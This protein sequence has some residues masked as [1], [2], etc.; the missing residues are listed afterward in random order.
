MSVSHVLETDSRRRSNGTTCRFP[1]SLRVFLRIALSYL[2]MQ[3]LLSVKTQLLVDA[4]L[5]AFLSASHPVSTNSHQPTPAMASPPPKLLRPIVDPSVCL[6]WYHGRCYY[7][8]CKYRHSL[9][10]TQMVDNVDSQSFLSAYCILIA[11]RPFR[12][13]PGTR[14]LRQRRRARSLRRLHRR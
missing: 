14:N 4:V 3:T 7:P 10:P 8:R 11:L 2:R 13:L 1:A 6:K 5:Y 9:P 12:K